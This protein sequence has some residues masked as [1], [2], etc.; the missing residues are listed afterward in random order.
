MRAPRALAARAAAALALLALTAAPAHA[1]LVQTGFGE[2]YDGLVHMVVTPADLLVVLALAL[3][4][5]SSGKPAARAALIGLPSAWLA[6]GVVG[7]WAGEASAR[8]WATALS[9]GVAGLLVA[10]GARLSTGLVLALGC[11]AGALHGRANGAE[12]EGRGLAL[13]GVVL[14]VFSLFAWTSAAVA[15]LERKWA[16]VAV[17]VAGSWIAAI[18]LL[19][20]G[21]L[22]R[23]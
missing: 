20:L 15:G 8:P 16:R 4:A 12:L 6:G 19:M 23:S 2:F 10:L 7:A 1:H 13:A 11:I 5:G 3:L 21:W 18:A 22:A 14:A 17:R 9:F